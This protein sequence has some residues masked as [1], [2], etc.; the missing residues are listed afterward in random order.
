[1]KKRRAV[2]G[3]IVTVVFSALF[4]GIAL[5]KTVDVTYP[6]GDPQTGTITEWEITPDGRVHCSGV[7]TA[8]NGYGAGILEVGKN[9]E[10]IL[11]TFDN[12]EDFVAAQKARGWEPFEVFLTRAC[13]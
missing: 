7:A 9:G 8:P 4:A 12:K 6:E 13:P 5:A 2:F 1:M 3:L 11:T 10:P